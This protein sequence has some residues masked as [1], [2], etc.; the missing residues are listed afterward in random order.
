MDVSESDEESGSEDESDTQD[1]EDESNVL[2]DSIINSKEV[3]DTDAEATGNDDTSD[4]TC[5]KSA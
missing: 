5:D 1:E 4:G 3:E 2:E